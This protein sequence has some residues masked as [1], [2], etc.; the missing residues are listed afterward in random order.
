M[1][2]IGW[3]CF[4]FQPRSYPK[5]WCKEQ[6]SP[7]GSGH[8]R[9]SG[10]RLACT[11][12][13]RTQRFASQTCLLLL[14]GIW[15]D[16][17]DHFQ[18]VYAIS[19][20][21]LDHAGFNDQCLRSQNKIIVTNRDPR[22]LEANQ[23]GC[24][25]INILVVECT[26]LP[27][28]LQWWFSLAHCTWY[29]IWRWVARISKSIAFGCLRA[30]EDIPQAEPWLFSLPMSSIY[31]PTWYPANSLQKTGSIPPYPIST[32]TGSMFNANAQAFMSR[33]HQT[34]Q[35]QLRLGWLGMLMHYVAL[36][37]WLSSSW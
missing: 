5:G 27:K 26:P 17:T 24:W 1:E 6:S 10:R 9:K 28:A 30:S 22:S 11:I 33:I 7:N 12:H 37:V 14:I 4:G 20:C 16:E 25:H 19:I 23:I 2:K 31:V 35:I 18:R 8:R 32:R 29:T 21:R 3:L 13:E 34:F 36:N 15:I